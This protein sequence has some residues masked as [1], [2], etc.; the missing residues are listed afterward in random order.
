MCIV[1]CVLVVFGFAAAPVGADDEA[2]TSLPNDS[3]ISA[4]GG[5]VV[6]S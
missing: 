2:L 6:W 4:Y 3:A 1:V 5:Y